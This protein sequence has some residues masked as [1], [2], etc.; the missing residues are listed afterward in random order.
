MFSEGYTFFIIVKRFSVKHVFIPY[1]GRS[2]SLHTSSELP[3][4]QSDKDSLPISLKRN[5]HKKHHHTVSNFFLSTSLT[6]QS[7]SMVISAKPGARRWFVSAELSW[8]RNLYDVSMTPECSGSLWLSS[9]SVIFMAIF[10]TTVHLHVIGE[11]VY[12]TDS[13]ID[14]VNFL[15]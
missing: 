15:P 2:C 8:G 7:Q 11:H 5:M 12:V 10:G 14:N 1:L 3:W 4:N 13:F 9:D 6:G